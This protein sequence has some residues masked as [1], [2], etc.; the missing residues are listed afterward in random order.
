MLRRQGWIT[1]MAGF[2]VVG[3]TDVRLLAVPTGSDTTVELLCPC[4][5]GP[6][7]A[8]PWA[9]VRVRDDERTVWCGP[10]RGCP[11]E[12]LVRF[13]DDLVR[14]ADGELAERYCLCG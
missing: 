1:S 11:A 2:R 10:D 12:T 3:D 5:E 7:D 6:D 4:P 8:G 13:I 9:A 14:R